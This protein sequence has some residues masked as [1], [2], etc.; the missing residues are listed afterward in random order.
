MV[1][2]NFKS[3]SQ[4]SSPFLGNA[5]AYKFGKQEY[6]P[7]GI[8]IVQDDIV[9]NLFRF[10]ASYRPFAQGSFVTATSGKP[11]IFDG[12]FIPDPALPPGTNVYNV[13]IY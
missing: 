3:G 13:P 2:L 12:T 10:Y 8:K 1:I 5:Q 7:S 9:P 11:F 4:T 6:A